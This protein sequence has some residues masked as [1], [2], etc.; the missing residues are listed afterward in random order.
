[1]T[2]TAEAA[3]P[4]NANQPV[5]D[6]YEVGEIPPLGHVPE[7]MHAWCIRQE[8]HGSPDTAMQIEVVPTWKIGEDECLILVMAAGVNYNGVWAALGKPISPIDGHKNPYHIA[9][10]DAAG[11]VYAVGAKVKRWKV[12]DEVVVHCNQDDGDDEECN[13]GD[14]MFSPSQRIWGYE[15]PDGSFA[16][17]ARVQ[18]RQLLPRPQHL[19]WEES[20]CYTLTLATAYRMLFGHRPHTLKPGQNVL[21]WGASGGL[22]SMAIQLIATAGANAIGVI[23]DD[24]KVDFVTQLGARGVI[25]RKNFQCWGQM[26]KVGTAEYNDWMKGARD[27]GKAIWNVT[28]KGNNVDM[29]FEHPGESTFPVSVLVVKRGG[30]V[31]ICAGTTGYNLTMDARYLWMH[32]KRVQGSHFANLMQASSANKLVQARRIDPCMSEV[33]SWHDIPKA[34]VKMWKNEHRPGNMAVLVSAPTTGLRTF[35]DVIEA[36][37]R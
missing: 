10:S 36:A 27:F 22:G 37:G 25:N 34:H 2:A 6:L 32:Q 9:G 8:R 11:I 15:T 7:K 30:M 33:Y 26:P 12:G 31:V 4:A 23:S 21:V 29:V 14:P 3:Q 35:D 5:K 28:G 20:A 13:G 24:D 17:F 18:A 1:M 19:T 16:Q